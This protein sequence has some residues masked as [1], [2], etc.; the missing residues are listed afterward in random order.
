MMTRR[1]TVFQAS[2]LNQRGRMV[3]DA[4]R[5]GEARVRDKDGFSL[6]V[7]PEHRVRALLGV[8]RA[9][10]N[11]ATLEEALAAG[12]AEPPLAGYGEWT[13]LR[14]LPPADLAEFVAAVRAALIAAAREEAT[15]ALDETLLAWRTTAEELADPKAR[16]VLLGEHR[17]EDFVEVTRPDAPT[18]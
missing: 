7:L 11:L 17:P 13:W 9:A 12:P 2:D 4:A 10:A 3:L 6:L 15:A 18:P 1:M 5:A 16:A 8:A 14:H